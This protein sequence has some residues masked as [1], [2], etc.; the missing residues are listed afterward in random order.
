[1]KSLEHTL[2]H[3]FTEED[4]LRHFSSRFGGWYKSGDTLE[5]L[6]VSDI[7]RVI[8]YHAQTR[9]KLEKRLEEELKEIPIEILQ[10]NPREAFF[11]F[12][13]QRTV[14][15][16]VASDY[17]RAMDRISIAR[18]VSKIIEEQ[19]GRKIE[20]IEKHHRVTHSYGT[21]DETR[22]NSRVKYRNN[23][24][25]LATRLLT[26]E[27]II[28][29]P[30][31]VD[32]LIF[33]PL[34]WYIGVTYGQEIFEEVQK[35]QNIIAPEK[36]DR[37]YQQTLARV[38]RSVKKENDVF[39]EY[40]ASEE[41]YAADPTIQRMAKFS[42]LKNITNYNFSKPKEGTT[43][44]QLTLREAE[45]FTELV[46]ECKKSVLDRHN[47]TYVK[48]P[49][50][51]FLLIGDHTIH[52]DQAYANQHEH[53]LEKYFEQ[54]ES[55]LETEGTLKLGLEKKHMRVIT[56]GTCGGLASVGRSKGIQRGDIVY[57]AQVVDETTIRSRKGRRALVEYGNIFLA[58]NLQTGRIVE[59]IP[60]LITGRALVTYNGGVNLNV[61]S[62]IE[63]DVGMLQDAKDQLVDLI[64]V[65]MENWAAWRAVAAI[66]N[67]Y[68]FDVRYGFFGV[69]SDCPTNSDNVAKGDLRDKRG[70]YLAVESMI[71]QFI[72]HRV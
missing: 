4:H 44:E 72:A 37:L 25:D 24:W 29:N 41:A 52:F 21:V 30:S 71:D 42:T 70:I 33:G 23:A 56:Y 58:R 10:S 62:V 46:D 40:P 2:Q 67:N 13:N 55:R 1:M 12:P 19:V 6:T 69:V 68:P 39:T 57:P 32:T 17:K 54:L 5:R 64:S 8:V 16:H 61:N 34:E 45:L 47:I 26:Y 28:K 20:V 59:A 66:N 48:D 11:Y 27:R 36:F 22:S 15:T 63:E 35:L 65:E 7:D 14:V 9:D 53:V 18:K 3:T 31:K 51:D 43:E 49:F 38:A 60:S 50:L